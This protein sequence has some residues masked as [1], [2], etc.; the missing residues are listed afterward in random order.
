MSKLPDL[1]GLAIFAKVVELRSFAAAA[2]ELALSKATVS[3][4][5]TRLEMRLGARLFNRTSRRLALTD[6]GQSLVEPA[7]RVLAQGEEAENTALAQSAAPRGL[8]R[9]AAPMSFGLSDVAPVL[10]QFLALYPEVTVD[11]HLSD[12]TIDLVGMG[13]DAALRIAALPDSSLVARRLRPVKRYVVGAPSYLARQGR[14]THPGHLAEH[15]CLGYAYMPTPDTWRFVNAA[16]EEASIRPAGPLRVNNADALMPALIAGQGLAVM[17]DFIA[18]AALADGRLEA[19]MP[20]WSPPPIALHLV[21][22]PGGPRPARVEAL[23]AFLTATLSGKT[24]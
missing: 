9:L 6:A 12:A 3:K 24:R 18:G 1:E 8:V 4:A 11:L 5:V 14:P 13:F 10:P 15:S 21:M 2:D 20:D 22:P 23:T 7:T 17:P 19:V 16:G